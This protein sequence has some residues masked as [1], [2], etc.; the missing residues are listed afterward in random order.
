MIKFQG[1]TYTY[2]NADRPAIRDVNL[3]ISRG[4]LALL[5]G[6]S[7]S[8]KST[9]L[10]CV[11]GLVPHFSGGIL[12]GSIRVAGY[13]PVKESPNRMSRIVGFVFQD[14]ES[15]FIVD[16]VE[17][18]IAFALENAG[19]SRPEMHERVNEV[20]EFMHLTSL[21]ERRLENLSGGE[22]QRVALAS[23]LAMQPEV[24][25]LDEPTSQLDPQAADE[26]LQLL[27]KMRDNYSLTILLAEHRLERILPYAD[28][29]IYLTEGGESMV[30][31][32]ARPVARSIPLAPPLVR[33]AKRAR[34]DPIPLS[35]KEGMELINHVDTNRPIDQTISKPTDKLQASIEVRGLCVKLANKMIL[36]NIDLDL[37]SG[38]VLALMGSNGAG[39]TTLLRTLVGLLQPNQ[40]TIRVNGLSTE[41][42]SVSEICRQVGYLPQDPNFLLF[43][44]SVQ[45][46]LEITIKNHKLELDI[47]QTANLL[48][49]LEL[50]DKRACYP[51]DLSSGEK[52]RVALAAV[53]I[54][55]PRAILLDEP[56][57]GLDYQ[58]KQRLSVLLRD[59]RA[60]GLAVLL[61]THDVE[62]AAE[63][64]DRVVLLERGKIIDTGSPAR[65]L[66]ESERFRTQIA[67]LFPGRGWL[68]PQDVPLR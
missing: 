63:V 11:N 59:W 35:I 66:S 58:A 45:D 65:I 64:A 24:I 38:E 28:H 17:D 47:D 30:H 15:Q 22:R 51:R 7:G 61:V 50:L 46:E 29:L 53:T 42:H 1:V 37:Y 14:P 16:R 40:G 48:S 19:V 5:C 32:P 6:N 49:R 21:R 68:T 43:A 62:L 41:T 44:E 10:R 25:V 8:G 67:Q 18:E 27:V 52:Q 56:T 55:E 13:N 33:L 31:G 9:L 57:R 3:E 23:A 12:N 36:E 39:K 54:T 60:A 20:M 4:S 34:L 26:L 2:P